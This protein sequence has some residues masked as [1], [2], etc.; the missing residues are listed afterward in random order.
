MVAEIWSASV[1]TRIGHQWWSSVFCQP[2]SVEYTCRMTEIGWFANRSCQQC[3][4]NDTL[5]VPSSSLLIQK[6]HS[7]WS[8][9]GYIRCGISS[10]VV[11][12]NAVCQIW[13]L[14]F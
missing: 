3:T 6:Q 5:V 8:S 1:G 2:V 4:E 10:A 12:V 14:N 11:N 9:F 13:R 7:I